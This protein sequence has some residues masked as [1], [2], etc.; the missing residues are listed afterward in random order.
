[1]DK[2]KEA[3][4][5]IIV[6]LVFNNA[7]FITTGKRAAAPCACLGRF[8]RRGLV[9][10]RSGLVSVGQA[11]S[12]RRSSAASRPTTTATPAALCPSRTTLPSG[13]S[14]AAVCRSAAALAVVMRRRVNFELFPFDNRA[15]SK[16]TKSRAS[17][18]S[19]P[20][21]PVRSAA[22]ASVGCA[23][24][25]R[26]RLHLP[27]APRLCAQPPERHVPQHQGVYDPLCLVHVRLESEGQRAV[28]VEAPRDKR[29]TAA[30]ATTGSCL[31]PFVQCPR[32]APQRH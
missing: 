27:A 7:G 22:A 24:C 29:L 13:L 30:V 5:D 10:Q 21:P 19:P 17:L 16:T 15:A 18:R 28:N 2:I 1:M 31:S 32:A 25:Q 12:P 6:Q 11:S 8:P 26:S 3:T 4:A 20:P 14:R 9:C 23:V